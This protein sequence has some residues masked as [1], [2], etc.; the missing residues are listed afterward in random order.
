MTS[1]TASTGTKHRAA[2]TFTAR[3]RLI[4][5]SSLA[6]ITSAFRT[7]NRY[8]QRR[9]FLERPDGEFEMPNRCWK[10]SPAEDAGDIIG[11]IQAPSAKFPMKYYDACFSLHHCEVLEGLTTAAGH[12]LTLAVRAE[13]EQCWGVYMF[14]RGTVGSKILCITSAA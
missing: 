13:A 8:Q 4:G 11:R 10:P 1:T 3:Q 7:L 2:S 14:K 9:A 6:H 12:A 5:N